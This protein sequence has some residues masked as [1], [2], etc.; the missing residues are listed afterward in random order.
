MC[1]VASLS[2]PRR[3]LCCR[4]PLPCL[5]FRSGGG[6]ICFCICSCCFVFGRCIC[7]LRRKSAVVL[8][9]AYSFVCHAAAERKN[10]LLST[11]SR[12][13][14]YLQPNVQ[15]RHHHHQNPAPPPLPGPLR[16]AAPPFH[17]KRSHQL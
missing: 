12:P 4:C 1:V 13:I 15:T 8:V 7:H 5:S 6:G 10:L 17:L 9:V 2:A 3:T 14:N 11:H 16:L